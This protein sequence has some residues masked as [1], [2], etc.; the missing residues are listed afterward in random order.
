M[1][2]HDSISVNRWTNKKTNPHAG[3]PTYKTPGGRNITYKSL[4]ERISALR[5]RKTM[6]LY[7]SR[8]LNYLRDLRDTMTSAQWQEYAAWHRTAAREDQASFVDLP[9]QKPSDNIIQAMLVSDLIKALDDM[10]HIPHRTKQ[11]MEVA[12]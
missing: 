3:E 10:E 4:S 7:P 1:Y 5:G 11:E 8:V 2:R 9:W 12:A 6:L